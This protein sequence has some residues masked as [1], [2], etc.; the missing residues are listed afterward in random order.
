M[1]STNYP[2]SYTDQ[3]QNKCQWKK[4]DISVLFQ[5]IRM[6]FITF[7]FSST[8]LVSLCFI[9]V[10]FLHIPDTFL[11][12][13]NTYSILSLCNSVLFWNIHVYL[14][15]NSPSTYTV[16]CISF[17]ALS[18]LFFWYKGQTK[19]VQPYKLITGYIYFTCLS[20]LQQLIILTFLFL[21]AIN[22]FWLIEQY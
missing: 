19:S 1:K 2:G 15:F 16:H 21:H 10:V 5:F 18:S 7:E 20:N 9:N 3:L 4:I 6:F 17:K 8:Q 22:L 13:E 14:S 12:D 11:W